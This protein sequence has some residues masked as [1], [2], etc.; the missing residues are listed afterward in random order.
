VIRCEHSTT[1]QILFLWNQIEGCFSAHDCEGQLAFR[2]NS[3]D[4]PLETSARPI[5]LAAAPSR[6][7]VRRQSS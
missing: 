4:A 5:D 1:Q 7:D 2:L 3:A 6:V